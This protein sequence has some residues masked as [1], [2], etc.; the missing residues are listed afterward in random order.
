[1]PTRAERLAHRW[2]TDFRPH[3]AFVP[4]VDQNKT[5]ED[6]EALADATCAQDVGAS[7][8]PVIDTAVRFAAAITAIELGRPL[9]EAE[10]GILAFDPIVHLR[11]DNAMRLILREMDSALTPETLVDTDGADLGGKSDLYVLLHAVGYAAFSCFYSTLE[12]SESG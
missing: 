8:S 6:V 4:D 7:A 3:F 5:A 9:Q 1:V 2:R 12:F 11:E 10:P